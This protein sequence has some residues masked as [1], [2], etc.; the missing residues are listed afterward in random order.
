MRKLV[1]GTLL[2]VAGSASAAPPD[3]S[4][5][6]SIK[7]IKPA[8]YPSATTV[9]LLDRQDVVF[10]KDGKF[11]N[12]RHEVTLVLTNDGRE[13]AASQTL[14]YTKDA[15]AYE[16]KTARVIKHDGTI[17]DV[18]AKDI[19]DTEQGGE[20][21]IYDPQGRAKKITVQGLAVGD[22]VEIEATMTRNLPTRENYFND[23]F[24]FQGTEPILESTYMIDGPAAMPLTSQMYHPERGS[25]VVA[26][27][28]TVGD[29]IHYQ[30]TAKNVSQLVP[31]QGMSYT[32]EVPVVIVTTDPSWQHFSKWWAE[33]TEKQMDPTPELKAKAEELVKGKKTE[34][35]K[36]KA[37]YD[38]V[39]AEIR[40]RGL[41]VG[42][43]T[44]YT[45]RKASETMNSRWGVCRDVSILLTSMLRTQGIKAYPVLT[46]VGDPVLPKIAY[47][48]FNH[49][50]VALPKAG[51]GWQYLDPTAKNEISMLPGNE[52]EQTTLVSTLGGEKLTSIPAADPSSNMGHAV[53]QTT[54]A[55]DGSMTST[56]KIT[57]KG[58]FDNIMR[59][60]VSMMSKDQQKQLVEQVIHRAL[61]DAKL[62]SY[63]TTPG[64]D[65][66]KPLE[67]TIGLTVPN[68]AIKTGDFRLLRTVVTSGA[69]GIAEA[70]LPQF[71]GSL[72]SR[73]YALDAQ[74]TFR[75]DQDETVTLPAEMK[76]V[77]M[78]NDAKAD[79]VVSALSSSCKRTS[80]TQLD[81]HRS[82]SL[83][84][85]FIQPAQ[86]TKLRDAIA[87]LSRVA[88]QPVVIGG[89]K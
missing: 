62:T 20:M 45:P 67:I 65:L 48:G 37:L 73:K 34:A 1:V 30:W 86:Y 7:K 46:N 88:R 2:L 42:P 58:I 22:A 25:K 33:V 89:A 36:I 60:V 32:N 87:K 10:Q 79:D 80:A 27:K 59:T 74:M 8:D 35:E 76:V 63:E 51:G 70:I 44:G 11:T 13:K 75:Y 61:P 78:P 21:N 14:Y 66:N 31:E 28:Q 47:D 19:L 40:Y 9:T 82:F 23:Q 6:E 29:R 69:L 16:I 17:V 24:A 68:A 39:S 77:A 50:I 54:I 71:L 72:P 5:V 38:F 64:M 26:T 12:T 81:C 52:A 15:E 18:P 84:S 4:I 56:V 3:P 41:G 57:G 83:K 43:R 85:R 49:A 55:A 53:A